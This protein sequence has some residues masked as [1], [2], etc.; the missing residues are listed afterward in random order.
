MLGCS[1]YIVKLNLNS[2]WCYHVFILITSRY[3]HLILIWNL[4]LL[5]YNWWL[6]H[7]KLLTLH[8]L[9]LAHNLLL[10]HLIRLLSNL[11]LSHLIRL[12]SL[13]KLRRHLLIFH[14]WWMNHLIL[15]WHLLINH[16]LLIKLNFLWYLI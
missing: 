13:W 9:W 3:S 15:K 2:A 7:L 12:L 5:A 8:L 10:S 6:S 11:L 16:R 4:L 14:L 1:F